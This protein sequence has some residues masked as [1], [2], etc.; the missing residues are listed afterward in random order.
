MVEFDIHPTA[1]GRIA[2]FPDS[3]LECRTNGKGITHEQTLAWLQSL[4]IGYGYTADG[5]RTFPLRGKGVGLMPSLDQ[6]LTAFPDKRLLIDQKD[7]YLRTIELLAQTLNELPNERRRQLFYWNDQRD[8]DAL[9][10]RTTGIRRL[11]P[12]R[13]EM[14]RCA[15]AWAARAGLGKLPAECTAGIAI[16]ARYL[17]RVPGW[18]GLILQKAR[19]ARVP[20]YVFDVDTPGDAR[21]V[22]DLPLDAIVTNRIDVVGPLLR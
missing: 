5:G 3:T 1:D 10:K 21:A 4:D 20:V 2:V 6:V 11:L 7:H 17:G 18:P 9:S 16:P 12:S 15:R 13:P 19:D 8:F 14:K 22:R